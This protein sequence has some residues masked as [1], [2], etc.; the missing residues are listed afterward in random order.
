MTSASVAGTLR[1][2]FAAQVAPTISAVVPDHPLER[3][4]LV[5]AFVIGLATTRYALAA[6]GVAALSQGQ[7]TA[8]ATPVVEQLLT[9]PAPAS[10]GI[11]APAGYPGDAAPSL[12]S[13]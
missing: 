8:W 13:S 5:G 9:G 12:A 10:P 11:A 2:V 7:I 3:A 6:P 4:S 1:E